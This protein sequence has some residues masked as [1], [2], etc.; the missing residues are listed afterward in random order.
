VRHD[1]YHASQGG[2]ATRQARGGLI[3]DVVKN[4]F[5]LH[6]KAPEQQPQTRL[7]ITQI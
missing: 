3:F 4:A 6:G 5:W 2:S 7:K 1:Q